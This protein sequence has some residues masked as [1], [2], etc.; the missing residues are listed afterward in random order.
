MRARNWLTEH[1]A[2]YAVPPQVLALVGDGLA[3]DDSWRNDT[4][5]RFSYRHNPGGDPYYNEI[6]VD[7]WVEHP[8]PY[9]RE[10]GG[11]RY[12]VMV[13]DGGGDADPD[14]VWTDDVE[15]ACEVFVIMRHDVVTGLR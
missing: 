12:F 11:A 6:V 1:G 10:S 14:A 4:C 9:E 3:S 5:P 8:D 7:I 13:S 15:L 2:E